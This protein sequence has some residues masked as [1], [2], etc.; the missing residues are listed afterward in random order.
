[1]DGKRSVLF[2]QIMRV[3]TEELPARPRYIFLENVPGIRTLALKQVARALSDAGYDA[4]WTTLRV[5]AIG[6]HHRRERWFCLA[7][8]RP[9]PAVA[10]PPGS[11]GEPDA[12]PEL[13]QP[14]DGGLQPELR[15]LAR[16]PAYQTRLW[17]REPGIPR[18]VDGVPSQL[19]RFHLRRN[20][21]L[22]NAVCPPQVLFA[23]RALAG[24]GPYPAKV[25]AG[26]RELPRLDQIADEFQGAC[27][28]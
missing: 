21:M 20:H 24:L 1:M 11:P 25:P 19:D 5:S 9:P 23:F 17:L 12:L 6:G 14:P 10:H 27:V 4:R 13:R 18:V 16:G 7:R 3:A 2:W 22:G 28:E 26:K 8:L 15:R